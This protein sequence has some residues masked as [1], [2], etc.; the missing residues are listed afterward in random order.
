MG[1][2]EYARKEKS[3]SHKLIPGR[4]RSALVFRFWFECTR[5]VQ[6]MIKMFRVLKL[7]VMN[8]CKHNELPGGI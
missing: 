5:T 2:F 6:T 7:C 4:N 1:S 3:W 8:Q